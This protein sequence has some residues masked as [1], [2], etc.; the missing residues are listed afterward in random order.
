M[1]CRCVRERPR[2]GRVLASGL[3]RRV[4]ASGLARLR[5]ASGPTCSTVA[6]VWAQSTASALRPQAST[7]QWGL[8]AISTP[9]APS[10]PLDSL[11]PPPPLRP[12]IPSTQH[13]RR[14]RGRNL[15][16]NRLC[17]YEPSLEPSGS[18]SVLQRSTVA[19]RVRMNVNHGVHLTKRVPP[20]G[21]PNRGNMA[22]QATP[23]PSQRARND[24]R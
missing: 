17:M 23:P 19:R 13:A 7:P 14:E 5:F 9:S 10:G 16:H 15:G 20:H 1:Q 21:A 12:A 8:E 4:L 6:E 24:I 18:P 2:V 22:N 11:C 3:A